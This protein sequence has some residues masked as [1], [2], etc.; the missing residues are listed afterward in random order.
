MWADDFRDR[1][2]RM[3]D[4]PRWQIGAAIFD[5]NIGRNATTHKAIGRVV[6]AVRRL[7][8]VRHHLGSERS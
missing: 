2:A 5:G 8:V 3:H 4:K 7:F 6:A 1:A